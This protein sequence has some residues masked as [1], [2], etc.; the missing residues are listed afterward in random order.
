MITI[1]PKIYSRYPGFHCAWMT[2]TNAGQTADRPALDLLKGEGIRQLKKQHAGYERSS[3]IR[4]EPVCRYV[5]YYKSFGRTY[6]V[7]QQLESILLK[8]KG[9]P[10]VGALIEAMFLAEVQNLLLTAGHDRNC[11]Q[12]KLNLQTADG[13]E[14]YHGITG[15]EQQ[16][17]AGDLCIS[18]ECGILSSILGGPDQRTKI[19]ADTKDVLY[20]V[21]GVDGVTKE[22]LSRHLE[23]IAACLGTVIPE[24]QIGPVML[25]AGT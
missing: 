25:P 7:L 11:L 10:A 1:D 13:T 3:F 15:K 4:T 21:Y 16:L 23:M 17:T 9:L 14:T 8:D 19:T 5:Q 18:D 20:F 24:A 6:P 12:G 22:Q 2:V